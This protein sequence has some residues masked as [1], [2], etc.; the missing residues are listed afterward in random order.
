MN[1]NTAE[2]LAKIGLAGI[3]MA[4]ILYMGYQ[5]KLNNDLISNHMNDSTAAIREN[6]QTQEI[7]IG[8]VRGLENS[9]E[10]RDKAMDVLI[11]F[12]LDR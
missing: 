10:E 9:L 3:C 11:E 8:A 7:L 5:A 12:L 4:L 1:N 2:K 6:T